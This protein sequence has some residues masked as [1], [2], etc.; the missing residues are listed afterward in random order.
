[1]EEKLSKSLDQI[2]TDKKVENMTPAQKAKVAKKKA[3]EQRMADYAEK[4]VQKLA[5]Q[6]EKQ[7]EYRKKQAADIEVAIGNLKREISI[8]FD[9]KSIIP[10]LEANLAKYGKVEFCRKSPVG[11]RCRYETLSAANKALKAKKFSVKLPVSFHPAEIKHHAVYF[12]APEEMG[13]L[14]QGI[15]DQI[16]EAMGGHGGVSSVKKKGRSV[17]IFFDSKETR[18]SLISVEGNSEVTV[19]IGDHSVALYAGVPPTLRKRR[20]AQKKADK[21][22]KRVQALSRAAGQPPPP[23]MLKSEH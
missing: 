4:K 13:E 3:H 8:D 5:M 12:N 19:E 7:A 2:I 16:K 9:I 15:L 10:G 20:A 1:M 22:A 11:L 18:E 23:K 21:E 14:D 17:V 6:Q